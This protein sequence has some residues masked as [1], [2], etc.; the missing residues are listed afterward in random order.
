VVRDAEGLAA[1]DRLIIPGGESTVMTRYLKRFSML[2][3]LKA[4]IAAGMPVWGVCA[5]SILLAE[6]VDGGPG[7]V[8]AL[9]VGVLRN[10]YGRQVDSFRAAV[11]VP[12][13]SLSGFPAV[14]I[15]APKIVAFDGGVEVLGRLDRDP[16][17]IRSGAVMATTFHPELTGFHEFHRFFLDISGGAV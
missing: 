3:A 11:D 15:R 9:A 2:E 14:F 13:L 16:V 17:F 7:P 5:G 8:G 10:A 12:A 6:T 4:R 1:A